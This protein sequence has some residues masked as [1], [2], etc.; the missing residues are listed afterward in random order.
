MWFVRLSGAALLTGAIVCN[1]KILR[2]RRVMRAA[3]AVL[4][5]SLAVLSGPAVSADDLCG[6]TIVS[7]LTLDH[8]LTCVGHGL[9]VGADGIRIK[10]KG[11][12]ITGSGTGVGS[13]FGIR[14][15]GRTNVTITGG[16]IRNFEAGVRVMNSTDVV[17]K[18][19]DLRD[20]GE[21]VDLAQGSVGNTVKENDFH[22]NS[23]RGIML[24][25]SVTDNVIK[26]NRFTG[27]RVGILVF[28]GVDNTIKENTISGTAL[29]GIRV[30]VFATGNLIIENAII[31]NPAGIE[32]LVTPTGSAI[33]NTFVENRIAENDCGLKGPTDGNTFRENVFEGNAVDSCP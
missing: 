1:Q 6:A 26:E 4:L 30:N 13:G 20:N 22:D 10:L 16:T 33:G 27:D 19:N 12:T 21:G 9:T 18:E 29:G 11:H 7:N 5:V 14:V 17:I 15:I 23:R 24:R 3:P 32:F 8:D 28:A 25:G 31:S 2:D